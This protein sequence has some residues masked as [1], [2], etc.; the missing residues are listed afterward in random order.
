MSRTQKKRASARHRRLIQFL[1]R[2]LDYIGLLASEG[3]S[4]ETLGRAAR[5][6]RRRIAD[7]GLVFPIPSMG[8]VRRLVEAVTPG[9][10]AHHADMLPGRADDWLRRAQE[11]EDPPAPV[12][13]EETAARLAI[14]EE[15]GV[16]SGDPS[17][18]TPVEESHICDGCQH[19]LD[20]CYPESPTHCTIKPAN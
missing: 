15:V 17:A 14:M 6:L 3:A 1:D 10:D 13:V 7:A 2:G 11:E 16:P 12:T 8:E 18:S 20:D 9:C 4:P 19:V 5:Q